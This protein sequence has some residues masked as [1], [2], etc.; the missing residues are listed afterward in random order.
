ML[1]LLPLLL[2]LASCHRLAL[3][4]RPH[5]AMTGSE[6]YR[7]ADSMHW[8]TREPIAQQQILAG[9]VPPFLRKL[10]KVYTWITDSTGHKIKAVFYV[11]PDYLSIGN[12]INWA[13]IPLTPMSA[14]AIAD[15][16]HCFMP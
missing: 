13:R 9:N 15:S 2:I 8:Q 14:Q 16:L 10:K 12:S 11:I 1:R 6:F 4:S 7:L 5:N 3:P